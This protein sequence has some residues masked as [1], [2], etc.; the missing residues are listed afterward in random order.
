MASETYQRSQQNTPLPESLSRSVTRNSQPPFESPLRKTSTADEERIHIDDPDRRFNK[1]T[2]GQESQNETQEAKP[3]V[4]T[5][6][7]EESEH[8]VP[9]LA[10]DEVAKAGQNE[11]LHPAVSP[12]FE[13]RNSQPHEEHASGALT[14]TSRPASR[15]GSI[16]QLHSASHSLSRFIS[17]QDE[18][19]HMHTPLEDVAEYEP[20]FDDSEE[21]K[22][23]THAERFKSRPDALQRRFPS[24]D[25][26]EDT[27]SSAMYEA[28]VSTPDLPSQMSQNKSELT[29]TATF[30]HPDAEHARKGE[31]TEADKARL[32]SREQRLAESR[33]L[34]HLRDDMP[35]N[36]RP[37]IAARFPSQDIWEDTPDSSQLVTTVGGS[38][39]D[40]EE[41]SPVDSRPPVPTRPA[42]SRLGEGASSA[43]IEPSVAPQI[44]ARPPKRLHQVPPA[45]AQ[46]TDPIP[47]NKEVSPTERQKPQV[48]PRPNRKPG[49]SDLSRVTSAG[50]NDSAESQVSAKPKPQVPARPA[51]G[52][53]ANLKGNFM[54]DLNKKL[55]LGPPKEKEREPE[56][57]AEAKPLEDARKSRARGPQRRAPAKASDQKPAFSFSVFSA[58]S[59][60]QI[61]ESDELSTVA[62]DKK[63]AQ[64]EPIAAV[65]HAESTEPLSK[66]EKNIAERP[67]DAPAPL[68]SGL[69]TNTAGEPA[70]P[71]AAGSDDSLEGELTRKTTATTISGDDID[72]ETSRPE[73]HML[74]ASQMTTASD[75]DAKD[76]KEQLERVPTRE[77]E[78]KAADEPIKVRNE[79]VSASQPDRA[80]THSFTGK[81]GNSIDQSA[82]QEASEAPGSDSPKEPMNEDDVDYGK[83]EAMTAA[84]DGKVTADEDPDTEFSSK[85]VVD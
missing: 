74:P 79:Q 11:W 23:L 56:P 68:A 85:K 17:H 36:S 60:W 9:I 28:E 33:Y 57:E 73:T 52:A 32:I 84:A 47:L 39:D 29:A 67:N 7:D 51:G 1:V 34:P 38:E 44:P 43:Q 16:Y 50:S 71:V 77:F 31:A 83:L 4:T 45:D 61:D 20:L 41:R 21:K 49:D 80:N 82:S 55:G 70:D 8:R 64:P 30:E 22:A 5:G 69:A 24:Q 76:V 25:I 27:P 35:T 65:D 14:P 15:P 48:P 59:L 63:T 3:Y 37:S 54:S 40:E 46:L 66:A 58:R 19:D 42:K 72:R 75:A 13:R 53:L 10:E 2:G 12:K 62:E 18:R 26:W 6:D 78:A 81:D